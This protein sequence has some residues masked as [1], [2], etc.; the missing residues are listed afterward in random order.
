[1]ALTKLGEYPTPEIRFVAGVLRQAFLIQWSDDTLPPG[2]F[3]PQT[4]EWRDVEQF[5]TEPQA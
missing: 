4:K 1:M 3:P 5:E 2:M